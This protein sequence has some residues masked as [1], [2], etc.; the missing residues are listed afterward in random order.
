MHKKKFFITVLVTGMGLLV[1]LTLNVAPL[2]SQGQGVA[3]AGPSI[4]QKTLVI[5]KTLMRM[6]T[7]EGEI[8]FELFDA[9]APDTVANF[10]KYVSDGHYNGT[11]FH[12]VIKGF[13]I[14]G[15]GFDTE[16]IQ[17]PTRDGIQNEADNGIKNEVGTIAMARTSDPHSATAQFFINVS[18]NEFLN[19]KSKDERGW[20]YTVFGKVVE[21]M[22]VVRKIEKVTTSQR[23]PHGDVPSSNILIEKIE[24][25]K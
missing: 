11:I 21:G 18:D 25:T 5:R 24:E 2:F 20:G 10:K 17:K 4:K 6:Y 22:D 13:M 16:M 7:T 19:H 12:R 15:G 3:F 8:V 1:A 9:E 14:Q 23:G